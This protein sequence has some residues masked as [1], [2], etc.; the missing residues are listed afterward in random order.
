MAAKTQQGPAS[1]FDLTDL[2]IPGP[3]LAGLQ[4]GAESLAGL[5]RGVE[6]ESLR[7][8]PDGRLSMRPHPPSLGSP[9]THPQ[10][11]TDFSEAQLELITGV[12]DTPEGCIAEL[13]AIH[14]FVY[15]GL[16]DELLW[17]ASM[18]CL[19]M[20]DDEIPVGRYGTSN[21]GLAKTVYRL[22]LGHRYGRLMQTISGIHYN[23]SLP[24]GFWPLYAQLKGRDADRG[25]VTESYF[26]LIR[27]FRRY[28]WLLILL[29]GAAPAICRS[30]AHGGGHGLAGF[31]E[32]T[33]YLPGATSLR[34]GRLGY[35]SDAQSSLH[36]SYNSLDS[37]AATMR[38]ALTQPYPLYEA[39][40]VRHGDE[41][42][43]LNTALLQIE[44]EFYGAIRPK[45]RIEPGERPLTALKRRGVEYVEVRCLD[46][47]PFLP[48]GID[49]AQM[50]FLDAFLLWCLLAPSAAD[51]PEE[52]RAMQAD[53]TAVV[54]R[55]REPGLAL[56]GGDRDRW[57]AA[58]LDQC[59]LAAEL[60]DGAQGG[61]RSSD[62]VRERRAHLRDPSRTPSAQVLETMRSGRQPFFRFALN[63][64]ERHRRWFSEQPLSATELARHEQRAEQRRIRSF[65]EQ[66]RIE[67]NSEESFDEFLAA[68][69]A[70]PE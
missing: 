16:D 60:L 53:Q 24:D 3:V 46:I 11:T 64:S 29:F 23:F 12:H 48:V 30:F 56:S 10:I 68:Y 27:N 55:G 18:P 31:D 40:G 38:D 28:S 7:V 33:L 47:N 65:D 36:I 49:A 45:R 20:E 26:A 50:R 15:H 14:R 5:R 25:F 2:A 54:E 17:A 69:L 57:A 4:A 70:P 19:V 6:K 1:R 59:A 22:G 52:S 8:R 61:Q 35:Q 32:G 13:T 67:A 34:M 66:R 43:Q 37:Y 21:I 41:Y 44:N 62:A 51:S 58:I 39:I 42:R 63:Q 9:L